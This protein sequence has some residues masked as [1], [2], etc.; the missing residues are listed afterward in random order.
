MGNSRKNV[1]KI[2]KEVPVQRD[3]CFEPELL[4]YG[5]ITGYRV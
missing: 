3:C 4:F 5:I 2:K 1:R